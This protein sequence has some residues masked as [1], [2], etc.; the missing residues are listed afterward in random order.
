MICWQ[1]RKR[2]S[3]D[4]FDGVQDTEVTSSD[5]S[6]QESLERMNHARSNVIQDILSSERD[7]VKHLK[8][9]IEVNWIFMD[10]LFVM[11]L[12]VSSYLLWSLVDP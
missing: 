12:L 6:R 5:Q 3:Y 2:Q 11:H 8:D 4:C 9:V 7:Y 10:F 1:L